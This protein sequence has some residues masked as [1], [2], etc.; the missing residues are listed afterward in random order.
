MIDPVDDPENRFASC[1]LQDGMLDVLVSYT[2]VIDPQHPVGHG[3]SVDVLVGYDAASGFDLASHCQVTAGEDDGRQWAA[4][5]SDLGDC[6]LA[7]SLAGDV[8]SLTLRCANM[9]SIPANV[10]TPADLTGASDPGA[11]MSA[12]ISPCPTP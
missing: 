7:P 5:C 4:T 10:G 11:A 6:Q 8:L 1:D 3:Y 2:S 12:R 9:P